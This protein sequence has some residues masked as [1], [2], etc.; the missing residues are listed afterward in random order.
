MYP[1]E[2]IYK[3]HWQYL[4]S[5]KFPKAEPRF[6]CHH[7]VYAQVKLQLVASN[8]DMHAGAKYIHNIIKIHEMLIYH[9]TSTPLF[10]DH[11]LSSAYN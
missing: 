11:Q 5:F 8:L 2:K 4:M 7:F 3:N 1:K 10:K 6:Y 9:Y